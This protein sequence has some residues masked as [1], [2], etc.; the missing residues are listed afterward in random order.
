MVKPT[1]QRISEIFAE[2]ESKFFSKVVDA[3]IVFN[4]NAQGVVE[5]LTL[6]QNG[7]EVQ[8]KKIK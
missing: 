7:N 3:Q 2:S 1:G 5:K 8:G 6:Y 4:K